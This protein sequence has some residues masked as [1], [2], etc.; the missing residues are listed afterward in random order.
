MN[1]QTEAVL[2]FINGRGAPFAEVAGYT[3]KSASA[4]TTA[5][6]TALIT[7][8]NTLNARGGWGPFVDAHNRIIR[9]VHGTL[10]GADAHAP[11]RFLPWHRLMVWAFERELRRIDPNVFIPY[12]EWAREPVP[13]WVPLITPITNART[14]PGNREVITRG[15]STDVLPTLRERTLMMTPLYFLDFSRNLEFAH[16]SVHMHIGGTMGDPSIS[17][18]DFLFFMHHCEVDRLWWTWQQRMIPAMLTAAGATMGSVG[19]ML[20]PLGVV[21]PGVVGVSAAVAALSATVNPVIVP[22]SD[23]HMDGWTK[24][25]GSAFRIADLLDISGAALG[26]AYDALAT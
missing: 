8:L 5:Q 15:P 25:D 13:S 23:E 18:G 26:Y 10:P 14:Q 9:L 2:G 17:P 20:G 12:W 21:L 22:A 24:A 6:R 11:E 1:M 19:S 7:A 3:R 16:N 4:L